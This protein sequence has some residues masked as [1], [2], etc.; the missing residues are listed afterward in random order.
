MAL[1]KCLFIFV[2]SC[3]LLILMVEVRECML[4]YCLHA[5]EQLLPSLHLF[6]QAL[7]PAP[8][9]HGL[10][11]GYGSFHQQYILDGK[12]IAVGVVDILPFCLSSVYLYYDPDYAFL[13]L[14][15]YSALRYI[16]SCSSSTQ[17]DSYATL[18]KSCISREKT[19][20]FFN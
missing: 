3:Y 20:I 18:H 16:L 13:S 15:T 9:E 10:T 6:F 11:H 1:F 8:G 19:L 12:I 14:G 2:I 7:M 5:R 4:V 17:V